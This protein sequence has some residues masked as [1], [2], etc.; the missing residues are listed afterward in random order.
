MIREMDT[1][2][3][4]LVAGGPGPIGGAVLGAV[5]SL[6]DEV[7]DGQPGVNLTNVAIGAAA[8]AVTSGTSVVLGRMGV[9]AGMRTYQAAKNGA[10]VAGTG[11]AVNNG[12]G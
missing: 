11:R 3:I 12:G 6:V 1:Q 8:G 7:T 5:A 2:E 9:S 4:E 10:I